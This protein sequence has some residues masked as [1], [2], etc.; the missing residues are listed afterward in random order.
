MDI[1]HGVAILDE[2]KKENEKWYWKLT[3]SCAILKVAKSILHSPHQY[4]NSSGREC[5]LL[6]MFTFSRKKTHG[7]KWLDDVLD[8]LDL[9]LTMMMWKKIAMKEILND[10]VMF[11]SFS[12]F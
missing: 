5:G 11:L 3:L 1:S 7:A 8:Q 9:G 10:F 6:V 12:S 2:E 4:D